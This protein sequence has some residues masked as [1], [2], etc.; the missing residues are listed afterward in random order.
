MG[1]LPLSRF[2]RRGSDRA[3]VQERPAARPLLPGGGR[4]PAL[5]ARPLLRAG[6]RDRGPGRRAPLVRRSPAA[7]PS[8]RE[9][10]R[11]PLPGAAGGAHRLRP[12]GGRGGDIARRPSAPGAPAPARDLRGSRARRPRRRPPL[13]GHGRRRAGP[14]LAR[15]GGRHARRHR[16][17]AP[18]PALPDRR[19]HRRAEGQAPPDRRLRGR[20]IPLRL[21]RARGRLA[22]ARPLRRGRPAPPRRLHLRVPDRDPDRAPGRAEAAD[23]AARLHRARAGRSQPLE[24]R[25]LGRVGAPRAATGRRGQLRPLHGRSLPPRDPVPALAPRQG[26]A[27]VHARPGRA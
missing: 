21:G 2:P 17:Q 5:A 18:R 25:A 9:P 3:A 1:R 19:A 6:R 4:A 24:H 14:R 16:G 11:A 7:R 8:G 15:D 12:A 20:G 23:H 13:P 26:A 10:H 22:A 27:P